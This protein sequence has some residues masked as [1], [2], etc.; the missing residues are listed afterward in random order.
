MYDVEA[1][2]CGYDCLGSSLRTTAISGGNVPANCQQRTR[3]LAGSWKLEMETAVV[4]KWILNV[5]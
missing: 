5:N 2:L 4:I 1:Q 3:Q